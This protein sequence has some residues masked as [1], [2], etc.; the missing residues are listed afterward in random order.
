MVAFVAVENGAG[1]LG[2]KQRDVLDADG[3][4]LKA[5]PEVTDKSPWKGQ[6]L[7]KD[8]FYKGRFNAL[9]KYKFKDWA[10]E[11]LSKDLL[12]D[13]NANRNIVQKIIV[14]VKAIPTARVL[15]CSSVNSMVKYIAKHCADTHVTI[16]TLVV[17]GHG[18][19]NSM[20]VGLGR[21]GC[22]DMSD[23]DDSKVLEG[24]KL[25]G[26][27]PEGGGKAPR[28]RE[29]APGNRAD[30]GACF[31]SLEPYAEVSPD[32]HSFHVFLMA[33]SIADDERIK[34]N[35]SLVKVAKWE[36]K[37]ALGKDVV[38]AA[39]KAGVE[40]EQLMTL[41]RD[42]TKYRLEAGGG[43]FKIGDLEFSSS[44]A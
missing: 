17:Y 24:R 36:L 15:M 6:G 44:E 11:G 29:I 35:E 14:A 38:V 28:V 1:V 33:C 22:F 18:G 41:V 26:L 25:L 4:R 31:Q 39:P 19:T 12:Q 21:I 42:L 13:A 7:D 2:F 23:R 34:P 40:D 16:D 30:W 8:D 9:N 43:D 37:A 5:F 32:T 10:R 27:E 3:A 20:N